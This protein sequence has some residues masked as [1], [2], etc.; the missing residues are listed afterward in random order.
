MYLLIV[1]SV[2]VHFTEPQCP[3]IYDVVSPLHDQVIVKIKVH[4]RRV[5]VYCNNILH[6]GDCNYGEWRF[7]PYL[8]PECKQS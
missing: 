8:P 2:Y 7:W 1:I 3:P 5:Q 6:F 4:G